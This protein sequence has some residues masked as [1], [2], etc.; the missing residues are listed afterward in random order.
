M[1]NLFWNKERLARLSVCC[2]P[3]LSSR[4]LTRLAEA[5]SWQEVWTA[6]LSKLLSY[7]VRTQSAEAFTAWR[8]QFALDVLLKAL[9]RDTISV[10]FADDPDYPALLGATSDP[11]QVLFLRGQLKPTPSVAVVGAR[12]MSDYGKRCVDEIIPPLIEAG[13]T[14]TS[15]LA[16]GVDGEAHTAT[17]DRGGT[18]WAVLGTGIDEASL[19][20]RAHAGLAHRILD[21]GGALLSEFPPGTGS[22]KEHFPQRNRII[23]GLSLAVVVIEAR[24][25]SGSLITAKSALEENREVLAVPGPI[26]SDGSRGTNQLIRAGARVCLGAEDVFS[27]LTL[28]RPQAVRQAL[29]GLPTDPIDQKILQAL[30]EPRHVDTLADLL[31]IGASALASRLSLLELSGFIAP[32]GGQVWARAGQRRRVRQKA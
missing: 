29:A 4:T 22:R 32:L 30:D 31:L 20:P 16:F 25:D 28:D 5:A 26:W 17:L 9:E 14:I 19:Y 27:A 24:E 21:G 1:E 11:P 6:P 13:L 18:T 8:K 10:L 2:C 12:R 3:N 15:G 23:A 7:G